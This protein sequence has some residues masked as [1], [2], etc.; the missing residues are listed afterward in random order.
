MTSK[1][2][3]MISDAITLPFDHGPPASCINPQCILFINIY[4]IKFEISIALIYKLLNIFAEISL[5]LDIFEYS[6]I[7]R[8]GF[9]LNIPYLLF[10]ILNLNLYISRY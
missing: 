2:F 1:L 10:Y 4:V 3:P 5:Y 9:F 6:Y 8:F 7:Y